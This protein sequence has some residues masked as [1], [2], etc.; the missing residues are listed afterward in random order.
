MNQSIAFPHLGIYLN[1][2]GSSFKIGG[3]T[4]AF[5]GVTLG[6]AILVGILIAAWRAKKTGQSPDLYYD[7]AI[8]SVI[9][10]VLGARIYYVIFT[11][12][13][14]KDHLGEIINL[15]QGG[16]A[17]YGGVIGAVIAVLVYSK[18]KKIKPAVLLDTAGC[19]LVVGQMIGRWGNFFNREV[20]G[21]YTDGL[22]AMRIP[23]SAARMSDVS[24]EMLQNA[25]TIDGMEYIQVTP[26]FLYESALCLVI[27]ILMLWYAK[28]KKF[29]G[30]VFVFYAFCYGVGRFFIEGIRTDQLK[31]PGTNLPVSQVLAGVAAVVCLGIILA[32]RIG[33][34]SKNNEK[35]II[36]ES[37]ALEKESASAVAVENNE[38]KKEVNTEI[39]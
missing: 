34:F 11:W 2:V 9:S 20:F 38:E 21:R 1:N 6:I 28:H 17:I 12:S 13:Y 33:L 32:G 35:M 3:F 24:D 14:Y 36:E 31:I 23:L 30:E 16:L 5:Y 29:D 22:F 39:P 26:T 37:E 19:G 7:L 10:G 15:R 4:V 8:Y 18:V 25:Q 27:F